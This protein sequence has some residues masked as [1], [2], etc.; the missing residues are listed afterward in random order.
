MK[1]SFNHLGLFSK[2]SYL[3]I[4]AAWAF[5]LAVIIDNYWSGT[6]T[7]QSV[8]TSIEKDIRSKQKDFFSVIQDTQ[9]IKKL[10]EQKFNRD[11]LNRFTSKNYFSYIYYSR[12]G[13]PDS[14]VFWSTQVVQPDAEIRSLKDGSYGFKLSN[15]WYVL[16]QKTKIINGQRHKLISLVPVKW[17]Y[18]ISNKYLKNSFTALD[19]IENEYSLSLTSGGLKITGISP[20]TLFYLTSANNVTASNNNLFAIILKMIGTFLL[21][22]FVHITAS[23][24]VIRKGFLT[25]FLY[26]F[27]PVILLRTLSY[28][29][30]IPFNLRQFDLFDPTIYASNFI[31]KSLGDLLINA[32]LFVWIILFSRHHLKHIAFKN[33][34]PKTRWLYVF[35][36]A[37]VIAMVLTTALIGQI[38]RSLVADSDISFEVT[39]FFTLSRYSVIGFIILS[40]LATGYFFLFQIMYYAIIPLYNNRLY[41]L[42]VALTVAGMLFLSF[43]I[44][45]PLV[46]FYLPLLVWLLMFIFLLDENQRRYQFSKIILS[47]YVFWIFFF[48]ISITIIIVSQNR[49]KELSARRNYAENLSNKSDPANEGMMNFVLA[50]FRN[51]R[52]ISVFDRF[53]NSEQNAHLKDS[54]ISE[55]FSGYLNKYATRIYTYNQFGD[56]LFNIDATPLSTLNALIETQAKPT[57]KPGLYYIDVSFDKFNYISKKEI[58]NDDGIVLGYIFIVSN[59]KNNATNELYPELFT[60]GNVNAIESSS[61]YAIAIYLGNKLTDSHNDYSFPTTIQPNNF[62]NNEFKSFYN[63]GYHELWYRASGEKVIVIAKKDNIF[64]EGITLFAYLFCSFL[65]LNGV[66]NLLNVVIQKRFNLKRIK[67]FSQLSIRSQI[68]GTIIS[69]SLFSFLII[70]ITTILFFISRY[71]SNNRERLS[72]IIQVMQNEV[73]N[74]LDTTNLANTGLHR[75][76]LTPGDGLAYAVNRIAEIHSADVNIYDLNGNLKVASLQ[77]PYQKGILSQK[78]DPVAFY[79]LKHLKDVQFFRDQKIGDLKYLSDYVPVRNRSGKELA[80]LNIPYFESQY[81]IDDEISNFLVTIINL[82]AFIFIIAG[83]IALIITSRITRSFSLIGNK[84]KEVNLGKINEA[85]I[86]RRNDEIGNLVKEYNKMVKKLDISAQLLARNE[87][88]DAWREMARQVAHE[89]KNPLTPM[90]LNLQYLQKAIESNSTNV[91]DISRYV[92]KVLVEQI[93]HLSLIAGDFAH[94]ANIGQ[95]NNQV[96]DLV[97]VLRQLTT[98]FSSN[99][100]VEVQLKLHNSELLINADKTQINR[101]FTNLLQNAIQSV[102]ETRTAQI[103]VETSSRG[104]DFVVIVRDNGK[105]IPAEMLSKIFTPNFTTK[106]SGTGLGLAMCKGIVEKSNGSIWFETTEHVGTTFFVKLPYATASVPSDIS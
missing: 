33:V 63:N 17:E 20:E 90:K 28:V 50:D 25:G 1:I 6:S 106:S 9:L 32:C 98:L 102:P 66:L 54:L 47:R 4:A 77:F 15:G 58:I 92:A 82:N 10:S 70:G 99:E 52:L 39:R 74:S 101:L 80:Y 21:L 14:C 65:F 36:G 12:P 62:L 88:E 27:A 5:T 91:K 51:D 72:R 37:L 103:L 81:N 46:S 105:G 55:N 13:M 34:I 96:F 2:N 53:K 43:Q 35:N 68:Q 100:N 19:D 57:A 61:T 23:A 97:D 24:V 75:L 60:R 30:P 76:E 31:N 87:R 64:I 7:P 22:I 44:A 79:H 8:K 11:L 94:F 83:I 40:C 42:Y 67:L 104:K 18:Y 93:D 85:I 3:L 78:M 45:S 26:L 59:P 56:P 16:N 38:I 84:M 89:I 48:S 73:R 69:I 95:T 49:I 86:W 71:H 29:L 41:W